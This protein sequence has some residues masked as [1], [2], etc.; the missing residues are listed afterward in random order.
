MTKQSFSLN[1]IDNTAKVKAESRKNDDFIVFYDGVTP[2]LRPAIC[3]NYLP[4]V[5]GKKA[6]H[7]N[8]KPSIVT[9]FEVSKNSLVAHGRFQYMNEWMARPWT[10]EDRRSFDAVLLEKSK[11]NERNYKKTMVAYNEREKLIKEFS[12]R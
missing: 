1:S 3:E 6:Y 4:P 2:I 12:K 11:Q 5:R 10:D 8:Q 9:D 7:Y